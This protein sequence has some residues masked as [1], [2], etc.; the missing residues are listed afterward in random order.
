M[1]PVTYKAKSL[2]HRTTQGEMWDIIALRE[3]GDEHAMHFV[4]DANF[5]ERFVDEFSGG[6]VLKIPSAVTVQNNL[7]SRPTT[8]NLQQ[9][10]PW[11]SQA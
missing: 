2:E 8:P 6:V 4:Q 10:L 5:Y 9:L 1:I 11:L 7:K 3:Y